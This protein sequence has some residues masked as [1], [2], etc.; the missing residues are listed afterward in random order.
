MNRAIAS[1][2]LFREATEFTENILNILKPEASVYSMRKL[3]TANPVI[4][5]RLA[6]AKDCLRK[7]VMDCTKEGPKIVPV[8]NKA[9]VATGWKGGFLGSVKVRALLSPQLVVV[10]SV[11]ATALPQPWNEKSLIALAKKTRPTFDA[12]HWDIDRRLFLVVP[13]GAGVGDAGADGDSSESESG[14]DDSGDDNAGQRI[15][16]SVATKKQLLRFARSVPFTNA[17]RIALVTRTAGQLRTMVRS[18]CEIRVEVIKE[19]GGASEADQAVGAAVAAPKATAKV[20]FMPYTS[21]PFDYATDGPDQAVIVAMLKQF[22]DQHPGRRYGPG[23]G[24]INL[25][26]A[27]DPCEL[28]KQYLGPDGDG[29]PQT[30]TDELWLRARRSSTQTSPIEVGA[31]PDS[32]PMYVYGYDL[33][34]LQ[35]AKLAV[36]WAS[37]SRP[38]F[39]IKSDTVRIM[40]LERELKVYFEGDRVLTEGIGILVGKIAVKLE[41]EGH[42]DSIMNFLKNNK[43]YD[44]RLVAREQFR[45]ARASGSAGAEAPQ[46]PSKKR[47][48]SS[49]PAPL[50]S[51]HVLAASTARDTFPVKL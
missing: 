39:Y 46:T 7:L 13:G 11:G 20:I 36:A 18:H 10:L 19:P 14:G 16:L 51:R 26:G 29:N 2:A 6:V 50:T 43:F 15:K 30:W 24:R 38:R 12:D 4:M 25:N 42:E 41:C 47:P 23:E 44:R 21:H 49:V 9:G 8:M 35:K 34:R 27:P 45:A 22:A 17:E 28:V 5:H 3:N 32:P 40:M 33:A 37:T 1:M 48:S 31:P